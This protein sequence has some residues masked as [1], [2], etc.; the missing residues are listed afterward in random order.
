MHEVLVNR[1]GGLSLPRKS[2]V[3]LTDRPDMTL[4]VYRGRKTTNQQ[5]NIDKKCMTS[6]SKMCDFRLKCTYYFEGKN[7]ILVEQIR[8]L[9]IIKEGRKRKEYICLPLHNIYINRPR[10]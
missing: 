10:F 7:L 8:E 5:I 3:R 2:V 9:T 1:L 6:C 4:D